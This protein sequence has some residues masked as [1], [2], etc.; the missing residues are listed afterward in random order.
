MTASA[1]TVKC[2]EVRQRES[3]E[4][5]ASPL[6]LNDVP[7]TY[8]PR[9]EKANALTHAVGIP[10]AI[11]LT[12]ALFTKAVGPFQTFSALAYGLGMLCVFTASSCY[13]AAKDPA[14]KRRLRIL[15]HSSIYVMIA[16]LYT[17]Y[18][19]VSLPDRG[20]IPMTVGVWCV[21]VIGILL[22]LTWVGRP[23]WLIGGLYVLLGW[24]IM[25]QGPA[26]HEVTGP[27]GFWLLIAGGVTCS[28]GVIFYVQKTKEFMHAVFHTFVLASMIPS[29]LSIYVYVL[30]GA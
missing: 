21:A 14:L 9:E 11:G 1:T 19:M 25:L 20:G 16:G 18:M 30:P 5:S 22:E 17:P 10:F 23:K 15:D 7:A 12:I 24:G 26:I 8:T 2:E 27:G 4:A 28:L 13:H 29:W 6:K 3:S